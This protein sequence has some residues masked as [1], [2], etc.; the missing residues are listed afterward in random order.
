M[1]RMRNWWILPFYHIATPKC[2]LILKTISETILTFSNIEPK[3]FFH[4]QSSRTTKAA[5]RYP[6]SYF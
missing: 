3:A 4:L 1:A 2:G 6:C 5:I